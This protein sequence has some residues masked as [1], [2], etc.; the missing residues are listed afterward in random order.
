MTIIHQKFFECKN[1][2]H[3][4]TSSDTVSFSYFPND[5]QKERDKLRKYFIDSIKTEGMKLLFDKLEPMP[6]HRACPICEGVFIEVKNFGY[7]YPSK[8]EERDFYKGQII[9]FDFP[10]H[11]S[12]KFTGDNLLE[13]LRGMLELAFFDDYKKFSFGIS[14]KNE[15]IK[16]F[17]IR[18]FDLYFENKA[19]I[20]DDEPFYRQLMATL[21]IK[22]RGTLVSER[23]YP[24]DLLFGSLQEE[25]YFGKECVFTIT[26]LPPK[27]DF[28]LQELI[29]LTAQLFDKSD[30]NH[31]VW[32][33]INGAEGGLSKRLQANFNKRVEQIL[34]RDGALF[35]GSTNGRPPFKLKAKTLVSNHLQDYPADYFR[36]LN[37]LIGEGQDNTNRSLGDI[38]KFSDE[39]IESNHDFIQWLF[40]LAEPSQSSFNAPVL[41]N[42]EILLIQRNTLA[43]ENLGKSARWFVAFLER[44]NHWLKSYNHNHLRITRAIK[45]LRLLSGVKIAENFRQMVLAAGAQ[46]NRGLDNAKKFWVEAMF[47][48][49]T[50]FSSGG[51]K[52]G[53]FANKYSGKTGCVKEGAEY[54]I[55]V[56][57]KPR[58]YVRSALREKMYEKYDKVSSGVFRVFITR[59]TEKGV[60]F[61]IIAPM[62]KIYCDDETG[63]F[64]VKL[65]HIELQKYRYIQKQ[66]SEEMSI[67]GI[68]FYFFENINQLHLAPEER[69][70]VEPNSIDFFYQC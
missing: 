11:V 19:K 16:A 38:F 48:P 37:F 63:S 50:I 55:Y 70:F 9:R 65:S 39:E 41:D 62:E 31:W 20:E 57:K 5:Q 36:C 66:L 45:S 67:D 29:R 14:A 12:V 22:S 27:K 23:D 2:G 59:V 24:F 4:C 52:W 68:P 10:K 60:N 42:A 30:E 25:E 51:Q 28:A 34:D 43:T 46:D 44:N 8:T 53:L 47:K 33:A 35:S 7:Q 6:K 69:E 15:Q 54:Q 64:L 56:G 40:P 1:C 13:A 49:D 61:E 18:Y 26:S 17:V 3:R 21:R 32:V 58:R